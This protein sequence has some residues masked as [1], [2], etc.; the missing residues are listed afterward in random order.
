MGYSREEA[1][2]SLRFSLSHRTTE[3]DISA[4]LDIIK[5]VIIDSR[6]IIRFIPCK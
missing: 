3:E 1:H 6:N 5:D 2:C 4:A